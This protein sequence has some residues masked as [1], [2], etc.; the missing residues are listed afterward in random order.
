MPYKRRP[1]K[2][3]KRRIQWKLTRCVFIVPSGQK[4]KAPCVQPLVLTMRQA[5]SHC[6]C[7][8]LVQET[9][10]ICLSFNGLMH[11]TLGKMEGG[12]PDGLEGVGE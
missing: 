7:Y 6:Q 2:R 8:Y 5:T 11:C 4:A 12:R 3:G 10:V 1:N 9:I